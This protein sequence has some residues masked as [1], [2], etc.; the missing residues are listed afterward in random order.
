MF[1]LFY[2][3]VLLRASCLIT[4]MSQ[5]KF[6]ALANMGTNDKKHNNHTHHEKGCDGPST[7]DFEPSPVYIAPRPLPR[8]PRPSRETST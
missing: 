1:A 5:F 2:F 3:S 4:N 8:E 6:V 7:S